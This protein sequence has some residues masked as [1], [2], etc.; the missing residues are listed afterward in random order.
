MRSPMSSQGVALF[1]GF[2]DLSRPCQSLDEIYKKGLIV[3]QLT[4]TGQD[5]E[6]L[7]TPKDKLQN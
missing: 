5:G 1:W 6:A 3:G 4:N 7:V 2:L